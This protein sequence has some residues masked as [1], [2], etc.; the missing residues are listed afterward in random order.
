MDP[1]TYNNFVE[2]IFQ[3]PNVDKTIQEQITLDLSDGTL[4][5]DSEENYARHILLTAYRS[6]YSIVT[7]FIPPYC[8][9]VTFYK[10][11]TG[12]VAVSSLDPNFGQNLSAIGFNFHVSKGAINCLT[13]AY[14]DSS[15]LNASMTENLVFAGIKNPRY[16]G[17][18]RSAL[19][20]NEGLHPQ[21]FKNGQIYIRLEV[22]GAAAM[23]I[24]RLM[25]YSHTKEVYEHPPT[26]KACDTQPARR[27]FVWRRPA[28]L[29]RVGFHQLFA[30]SKVDF[31]VGPSAVFND[32]F[33]NTHKGSYARNVE[34]IGGEISAHLRPVVG[35]GLAMLN[36]NATNAGIAVV[37]GLFTSTKRQHTQ[38]GAGQVN[39]EIH[40]PLPDKN[41]PSG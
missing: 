33:Y 11:T 24:S 41:S 31:A 13:K 21:H 37:I 23:D 1:V 35:R 18:H 3:S 7:R 36:L 6:L 16:E 30:D 26:E 19:E 12:F 20:A 25:E 8:S 17:A 9:T 38:Q 15:I 4:A 14:A 2:T 5:Y 22:A 29:L 40:P 28:N 10:E 32:S 39:L 27:R 34:V